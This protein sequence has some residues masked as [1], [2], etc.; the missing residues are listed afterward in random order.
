MRNVCF[1]VAM[2]LWAV[3]G[4]AKKP[5]P[6]GVKLKQINDA[7]LAAGFE[8]G[9]FQPADARGF[10][11]QHCSAGLLDGVEAVVC[12]LASP[13]AA[14]AARKAG[15]A[16]IDKALTG[17]VLEN[18]NTVLALADRAKVDP[19]GKRLRKITQAYRDAR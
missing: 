3:S 8:L 12:E 4:C 9:S 19:S 7:F 11:A 10:G 13:E 14:P 16:W 2:A 5:T 17:V 15:E 6:G 18:G 1:V